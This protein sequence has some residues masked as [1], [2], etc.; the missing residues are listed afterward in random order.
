MDFE[1][2]D[3]TRLEI[4]TIDQC[5]ANKLEPEECDSLARMLASCKSLVAL[6]LKFCI[7]WDDETEWLIN[8]LPHLSRSLTHLDLSGNNMG[9]ER[10]KHLAG[11]LAQMTRLTH[12]VLGGNH[13]QVGGARSLCTVLDKMPQLT[14]LNLAV[15]MMQSEGIIALCGVVVNLHH[16]T[17]LDL[18]WNEMRPVGL[19]HLVV[20]VAHMPQLK[21]LNVRGNYLDETTKDDARHMLTKQNPNLE[22]LVL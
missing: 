5:L 17:W 19:R 16:L 22:E 12:L 10:I 9:A 15:N 3:T 7:G 18:N 20:H 6:S 13:I 21:Y 8:S 2:V 1:D 4:L 14:H 11:A